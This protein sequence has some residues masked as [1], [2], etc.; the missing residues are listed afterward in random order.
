MSNGSPPQIVVDI[1]LIK[2]PVC[3]GDTA[4]VEATAFPP[5]ANVSWF[6]DGAFTVSAL[7]QKN[8]I[9]VAPTTPGRLVEARLDNTLSLTV[10]KPAIALQLDVDPDPVRLSA[11]PR[12]PVITATA[13]GIGG[14]LAGLTWSVS[15]G[16]HFS[17]CPPNGPANRASQRDILPSITG[18]Q[19]TID[20]GDE[21]IGGAVTITAQGT[22]NGCPVSASAGMNVESTN[23]PLDVL[24]TALPHATL[25]LIACRES[26][27]RQFEAPAD[28]GTGQCPFF[29][30]GGRVG[31][32]QIADPS[33]EEIWNWAANV[34]SGIER[35]QES[36]DAARD[37]PD[38]VR[39]SAGFQDLVAQF[40]QQRQ[41]QGE[42]PLNIELPDF[43]SGNFDDDRQQ[44]E[45]DAIR[46]YNGWF[47]TD[48]FGFALHEFRV[49]I[50]P[51]GG[52]DTLRVIQRSD[53]VGEAQWERVPAGDRPV[54]GVCNDP[55]YVDSVLALQGICGPQGPFPNPCGATL[56]FLD[57][58]NQPL[59]PASQALS[60]SNHVSSDDAL[61]PENAGFA[62]VAGDRHAFR[63][64]V[65]DPAATGGSVTVRV[66]ANDGRPM[67]VTLGQKS[68]D[69]YRGPFM[70]LVTDRFDRAALP[71]Q[72][73]LCELGDTVQMRYQS[74]PNCADTQGIQVGRPPGEDDNDRFSH[75]RHDIREL[76]VNVIVFSR[77]GEAELDGAIDATQTTIRVSTLDEAHPSGWIQID[78][79]F[80]R[81]E[82]VD[83]ASGEFQNC[84]RLG[85]KTHADQAKVV[86]SS[87]TPAVSRR[88]VSLDLRTVDERFAQSGIRIK[89][90]VVPDFNGTSGRVLPPV[91][92]SG[93]QATGGPF[94][95]QLGPTAAEAFLTTLKDS[96]LH[97]ID[98]FYLHGPITLRNTGNTLSAYAR[99]ASFNGS[100]N[101]VN[102]NFIVIDG[103]H[104]RG[105]LVL[106]HE[107]MHILLNRGHQDPPL[108]PST[109][110]FQHSLGD[111]GVGSTKRISPYPDVL[112]AAGPTETETM[113]THTES[114]PT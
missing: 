69:A 75:L 57:H 64:E 4:I 5:D 35:F 72:H 6:I 112:F 52:Q 20:M 11:E 102:Q 44:L 22:I 110:L 84:T 26:G 66:R 32:M 114:L 81:Y 21:V 40:N 104:Q 62:D 30:C 13:V 86:Y 101:N 16:F 10:F 98:I 111:K 12:L 91:M 46:G 38:Q 105:S 73:L 3:P 14:T 25:R 85:N 41:A 18:N 107:I 49:A 113:R 90:P 63:L 74:A 33:D 60:V 27:Q 54:T 45:L 31:L 103:D 92:L 24:H 108:E 96:D 88:Q 94:T 7:S 23:P 97:S 36:V 43:T 2:E 89:K 19:I 109:S 58:V 55:D 1:Q 71:K 59:D 80:I 77:R 50:D 82:A 67:T 37:Y 68:G 61:G 65:R 78:D 28:G 76:K 39:N 8:T 29:G 15:A 51:I 95:P 17:D 42:S 53:Q 48:R 47:G 83:V 99:P 56:R 87:T 106:A 100:G 9:E 70:R 93:Y 79:E 34:A